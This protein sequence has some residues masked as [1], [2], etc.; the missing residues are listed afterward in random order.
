MTL[1]M[2]YR[3]LSTLNCVLPREKGHSG[4]IQAL[5][6]ICHQMKASL[7]IL[8]PSSWLLRQYINRT[9]CKKKFHGPVVSVVRAQLMNN[10]GNSFS[11]FFS[12]LSNKDWLALVKHSKKKMKSSN[13]ALR[14]YCAYLE[15]LTKVSIIFV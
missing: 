6:E 15:V 14:Q 3:N 10:L 5:T 4:L 11:F 9:P 1:F 2:K 13:R 8:W 7:N 12:L